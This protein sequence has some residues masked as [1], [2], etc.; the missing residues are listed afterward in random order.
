MKDLGHCDTSVLR[1]VVKLL[2]P[3]RFWGSIRMYNESTYLKSGM[4]ME[5]LGDYIPNPRNT[6]LLHTVSG[7]NKNVLRQV[8]R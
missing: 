5:K 2:L 6:P 3:S 8:P 4:P 7:D 1:L